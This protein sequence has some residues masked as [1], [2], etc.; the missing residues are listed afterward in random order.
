MSM[1]WRDKIV[2]VTGGSRGLGRAIAAAFADQ[3]ARIVLAARNEDTLARTS[4]ELHGS[5]ADVLG[6]ATDV[7]VAEQVDALVQAAVNRYGRI[8][9]LVNAAGKSSRGRAVDTDVAAFRDAM[10][11]NFLGLVRCTRAALPQLIQNQGHIVNVASLAGKTASPHMGAYPASKFPVVA[12]SQQLRLELAS[13]GVHTLLV[14]P[15]PVGRDDAGT[16]Y[17]QQ[18][19]DLPNSARQPGGGVR[20]SLIDPE[21]LARKI[22]R[23]CERRQAELVVPGRARIL[24]ALGQLWPGLGDWMVR[25]ATR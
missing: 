14:C 13:A 9:V 4:A 15:G 12:Y 1:P 11:L 8:D 21:W 23:A 2:V 22:V 10:E 20:L 16:R 17:D 6:V 18:T 19:G 7:T 3:G 24:F 25:R 5:G